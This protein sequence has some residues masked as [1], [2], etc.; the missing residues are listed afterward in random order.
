MAVLRNF[1]RL[2]VYFTSIVYGYN[3]EQTTTMED[4]K[5]L[6]LYYIFELYK[7]VSGPC[8]VR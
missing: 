6:D 8:N 7:V 5:I 3:T 1:L 2:V 4:R